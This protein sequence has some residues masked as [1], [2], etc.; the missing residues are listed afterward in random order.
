MQK[1]KSCWIALA[2][3]AGISTISAEANAQEKPADAVE[4]GPPA[5][6]LEAWETGE[7]P[8]VPANGPPA[9]VVE[10]WKNGERPH[11]PAGP[12]PWIT[13]RHEMAH[14]FGLPGPPA[15]VIQAWQNGGGFDLPGPPDFVLSLF[16]F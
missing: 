1:M 15:E 6:V 5:W 4:V 11:R 7:E 3:V 14:K 12:P 13:S 10:A 8:V 16:G 9:W 2:L